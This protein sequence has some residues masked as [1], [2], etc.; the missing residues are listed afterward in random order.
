MRIASLLIVC[1]A[2]AGGLVGCVD[3]NGSSLFISGNIAPDESCTISVD[4]EIVTRGRLNVEFNSGAYTFHPIYNNSLIKNSSDAPPRPDPNGLLVDGAEVEILDSAGNTVGFGG[5][6]NP[7]T[8][9]NTSFVPSSSGPSSPG[10]AA[11]VL[12]IIPPAYIQELNNSFLPADP[13][14]R[15]QLLINI[16]PFAETL[17]HTGVDGREF[18]WP[19]DLCRGRDCLFVPVTADEVH[20]CCLPGQDSLCPD[21]ILPAEAP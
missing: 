19:V 4:N 21:S 15:G 8:V 5:L 7:F 11:G 20:S 9:S 1:A 14:A 17:G 16:Q 3:D 2:L 13:N 18:L 10:T 12:E 6:P